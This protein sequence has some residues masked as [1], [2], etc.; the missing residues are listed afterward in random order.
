MAETTATYQV[1]PELAPETRAPGEML[2]QAYQALDA[3]EH[4]IRAGARGDLD[5]EGRDAART[6]M[7]N[8]LD[9]MAHAIG[10]ERQQVTALEQRLEAHSDV[11]YSFQNWLMAGACMATELVALER[12]RQ[13]LLA[14]R[15]ADAPGQ[16]GEGGRS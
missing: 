6:A 11:T 8:A 3:F 2:E 13:A 9:R 15:A 7:G 14:A 5:E 4:A 16:R 1:A 10:D 12:V